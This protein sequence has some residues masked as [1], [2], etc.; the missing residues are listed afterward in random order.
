MAGDPQAQKWVS[1]LHIE[2]SVELLPGVRHAE[3]ADVFR[4]AQIA[5]SLGIH[6]GTPNTL[7][8]AMACG[9]FPIAGDLESIREWIQQGKNGLIVDPTDPDDLADAILEGLEKKDLRQSAA[10]LNQAIILQRA[11]YARCMERAEEFYRQVLSANRGTA[12]LS[13]G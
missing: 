7:L 1:H 12:A 5:V 2:Q 8:E 9:C 10:G 4:R 6:D 11:E 13:T 3:M